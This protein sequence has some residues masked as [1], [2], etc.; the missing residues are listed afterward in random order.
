MQPAAA[1]HDI[2][3]AALP[4]TGDALLP[5][6]NQLRDGDPLYWSAASQCWIVSG[7]AE[8][9]EGFSGTLPLSSTHI[10]ASLYRSMP[11]EQMQVRLPNTLRY[12]PKIVTN[13]D[14]EE[15]AHL[16]RLLVK[17]FNRKLVEDLRPF[18]RDRVALLLDKAAA[19][20]EVE[21]HE[22]IARQLPGAVILK[23]LGMAPEN[24][25]RLKGWADG[26]TAALTSF[27][28]RPEWLDQLE[29]VVTDMVQMFRAEIE[30]RKRQPK[31]DLITQLLTV[32]E[33]DERLTMD[34]IIATLILAIVAGHDTTNNTLT[35]GIRAMA[36]QPRAWEYWRTHLD[37]GIDCAMELMRY[38]AMSTALPRI[39]ARDFE[40]RGRHL[41][42]GQLLMLMIA[43]GN[44]DP[45]VYAHAEQLDFERPNN[46]QALVFGP[47]LHHCI[48]HLLAK[49][50][51]SEFFGALV[52]R[53]EGV[54]IL[55]PPQFTPALVFRSVTALRLR[56]HPRGLS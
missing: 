15:H 49:L 50:Q 21:F 7:H 47:G 37:R 34:Q 24:L 17:A 38:I 14:G 4:P 41:R 48:G 18:V 8:V 19:Q 52:Q 36:T 23:L 10:P 16:R 13:L 3:L 35:L 56:F 53:F 20:R 44:R 39:V 25:A 9:F 1:F 42:Q 55:E 11:L 32:A 26:V 40:W 54:E 28:P 29:I 51:V 30:D 46:D 22:Q 43:G 27:N 31:S 5:E 33:G 6:I 12:M 2:N 45:K